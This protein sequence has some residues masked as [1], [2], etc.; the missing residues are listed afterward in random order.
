MSAGEH[1]D[2]AWKARISHYT[3]QEQLTA[4][5]AL[6][7]QAKAEA[8]QAVPVT[9][10]LRAATAICLSDPQLRARMIELARGQWR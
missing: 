2:T 7:T 1:Q 6:R 10:L 3:S 8:G 5:E 9:A 4:L